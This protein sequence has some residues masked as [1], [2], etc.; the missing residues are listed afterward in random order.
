MCIKCLNNKLESIAEYDK[1]VSEYLDKLT[2]ECCK[3]YPRFLLSVNNDMKILCLT[4]IKRKTQICPNEYKKV[5]QFECMV[6]LRIKNRLNNALESIDN[7][8][9][10]IINQEYLNKMNEL[11]D[12]NDMVKEIEEADHR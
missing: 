3:S 10:E 5:S 1:E 11:K 4:K 7:C 12:L 8:K 9:E 6:Q 2:C